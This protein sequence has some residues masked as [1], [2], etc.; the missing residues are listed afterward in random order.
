VF[1]D[2]IY[3]RVAF[4][5]RLHIDDIDALYAIQKNLGIGSVTSH[6]TGSSCIYTVYSVSEILRVLIPIFDT[7]P[8][9]T[10]KMFDY[11]D[12]KE[13]VLLLNSLPSTQVKDKNLERAQTIIKGMNSSRVKFNTLTTN[14]IDPF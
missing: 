2:R 1:F 10:T 4:R 8:L 7:I 6:T 12:F 3:L 14:P 9:R 13:I 11:L 5:I